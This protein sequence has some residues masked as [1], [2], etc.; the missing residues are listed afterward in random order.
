MVWVDTTSSVD[1]S[2][3]PSGVVTE[4]PETQGGD[5]GD[6]DNVRKDPYGGES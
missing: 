1:G 3:D 6:F 5:R 4:V 2:G